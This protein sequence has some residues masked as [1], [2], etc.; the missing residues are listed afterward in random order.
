MLDLNTEEQTKSGQH[1]GKLVEVFASKGDDKAFLF[2]EPMKKKKR[3]VCKV[4]YL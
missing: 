2:T 4:F 3:K 1:G